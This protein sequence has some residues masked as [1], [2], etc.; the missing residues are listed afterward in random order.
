MTGQPA[1]QLSAAPEN[2][3]DAR[4]ITQPVSYLSLGE[5]RR[6]GDVS[7]RALAAAFKTAHWDQVV[8]GMVVFREERPPE[9]V[10][11]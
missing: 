6:M 8:D 7:A 3:L 9:F 11:P 2:S 10:R 5:L 4:A 1:R